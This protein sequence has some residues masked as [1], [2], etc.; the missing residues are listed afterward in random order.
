MHV[1]CWKQNYYKN[2]CARESKLILLILKIVYMSTIKINIKVKCLLWTYIGD[3][4]K[5]KI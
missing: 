2:H 4:P 1:F 5:E 3:S